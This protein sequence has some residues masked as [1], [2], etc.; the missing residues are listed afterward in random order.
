LLVSHEVLRWRDDGPANKAALV[1]AHA[2]MRDAA[3]DLLTESDRALGHRLAARWFESAERVNPMVT[4]QHYARAGDSTGAGHWYLRATIEA[5]EIGDFSATTGSAEQALL[6]E[7][8]AGERGHVQAVAAHAYRLLGNVERSKL[9][10][11]DAL[12]ALPPNSPLWR[13][14]ARTAMMAGASTGRHRDGG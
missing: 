7:L 9:L 1:F 14:A 10:S 12:R 4:A 3:Y 13:E 8:S 11:A 6:C 5:F 2:L